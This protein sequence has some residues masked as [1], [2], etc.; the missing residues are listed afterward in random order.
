M[1]ALKSMRKIYS[2]LYAKKSLQKEILFM[3]FKQIIFLI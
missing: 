1:K 3:Y 2:K